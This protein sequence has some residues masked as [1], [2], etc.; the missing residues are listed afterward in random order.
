MEL[1]QYGMDCRNTGLS[2]IIQLL[3]DT[4]EIIPESKFPLFL[5]Q[6]AKEFLYTKTKKLQEI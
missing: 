5:D 2:W 3:L 1:L 4:G 6:K